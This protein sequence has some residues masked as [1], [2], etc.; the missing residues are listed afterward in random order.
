M[1]QQMSIGLVSVAILA[2]LVLGAQDKYTVK[3]PGGLAL[4]EFRGSL[5]SG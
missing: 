4:S 1:K 3:V 2:G 5:L